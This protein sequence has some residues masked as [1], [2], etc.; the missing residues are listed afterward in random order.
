[1][2]STVKKLEKSTVEIR[3]TVPAD[4]FNAAMNTAYQKQ[5]GYFSAQPRVFGVVQRGVALYKLLCLFTRQMQSF[6]V[7]KNIGYFH[8]GQPVLARA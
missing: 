1:M 4:Q 8:I 5:R 2:A 6:A 7:G 3:L